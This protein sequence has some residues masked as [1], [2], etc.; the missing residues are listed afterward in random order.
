MTASPAFRYAVAEDAATLLGVIEEAYRGEA[1]AGRWDSESHLLRGPRTSLDEVAALIADEESRIVVAH[2]GARILACALIQK[3]VHVDGRAP[4]D[5]AAYFGMFAVARR[6]VGVGDALLAECERRV[7]SLWGASALSMT[8]ISVRVEL[9]AWYERRGY[10]RTGVRIA[11]PFDE[12]TGEVT[13]DFDLV[14]L[15]KPL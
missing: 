11:F 8:V 3:S 1:S 13:R 5:D 14:E 15:R 10:H 4:S 9:I 6:G 7:V 12:T 2:E